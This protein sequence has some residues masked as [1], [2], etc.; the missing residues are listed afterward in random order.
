MSISETVP[1]APED[2]QN[3]ATW[4]LVCGGATIVVGALAILFPFAATLATNLVLGAAL[5]VSGLFHLARAIFAKGVE[6]KLWTLVFGLLSVVAGAV[7]LLYP[8][9]AVVALTMI[10][11]A[12]FIAGGIAKLVASWYLSPP[13]RRRADLPRLR[14]WGWFAFSALLSTALGVLLLIGL[15]GTALWAIGLLVGI[16]LLFL[17]ISEIA[18]ARAMRQ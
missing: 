5:A 14:G 17:G 1:N 12:F 2:R 16:D 18:L 8:V 11:A 4:L 13:Y 3:V 6:S 10:L 7:L 9:E 15:P